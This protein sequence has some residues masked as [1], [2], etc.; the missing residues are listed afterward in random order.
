MKVAAAGAMAEGVSLPV[1]KVE[2]RPG[3]TDLVANEYRGK[4][5]WALLA[6]CLRMGLSAL[7]SFGDKMTGNGDCEGDADV[8]SK[9]GWA[10]QAI[11]S[12][13]ALMLYPIPS[14][15]VSG[16]SPGFLLSSPW[17]MVLL[18]KWYG[19][20]P[21]VPVRV[22]DAV[23]G[24]LTVREL[25]VILPVHF[26]SVLI[27]A[28]L[29]RLALP[30]S[31]VSHALD[32]VPYSEDRPWIADFVSEVIICAAFVISVRVVPELLW[33][34]RYHWAWITTIVYPIFILSVDAGGM[35]SALCPDLIYAL[36]YIRQKE[37]GI[38][39]LPAGISSHVLGPILGGVLGG[40]IMT[41]VFPD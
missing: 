21:N 7:A 36:Q 4:F 34:N 13:V 12:V 39:A 19:F 23:R 25:A 16:M 11:Y 17:L 37:E 6:L 14:R 32:P 33:L 38:G 20:V 22:S 10:I 26:I 31:L 5:I 1:R 35:G 29:L 8:E 18:A 24:I 2:P 15:I 3:I 41:W 9:R 40:R 28:M 30:P 27:C